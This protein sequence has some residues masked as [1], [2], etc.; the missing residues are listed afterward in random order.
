[1]GRKQKQMWVNKINIGCK[2]EVKYANLYLTLK[3]NGT[4]TGSNKP[5]TK[6][7]RLIKIYLIK[8]FYIKSVKQFIYFTI[9]HKYFV[10]Q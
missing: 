4:G 1:M 6:N 7:I 10:M 2:T 5:I 3:L 9:L 8:I